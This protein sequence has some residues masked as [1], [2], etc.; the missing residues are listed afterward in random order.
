MLY[1]VIT[2]ETS[3][4]LRLYNK[5][6]EN[7]NNIRLSLAGGNESPFLINR[8]TSYNV[9]YTNLLRYRKQPV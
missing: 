1:E 7:V 2:T 9:C 3:N 5:G 4:L 6:N 8:I